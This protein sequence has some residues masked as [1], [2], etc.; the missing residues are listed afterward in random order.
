MRRLQYYVDL[1]G[2]M[3]TDN[4]IAVYFQTL[5][6]PYIIPMIRDKKGHMPLSSLLGT[7]KLCKLTLGNGTTPQWESSSIPICDKGM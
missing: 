1:L 2:I 7:M 3:G 5:F 6:K 4:F